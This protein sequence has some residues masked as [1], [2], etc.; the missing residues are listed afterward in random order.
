MIGA[1]AERFAL[2]GKVQVQ[3]VSENFG[4]AGGES[5]PDPAAGSSSQSTVADPSSPPTESVPATPAA[6]MPFGEGPVA[7]GPEARDLLGVE[8]VSM[9]RG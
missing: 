8:S 9:P 5:A 4:V 7:D 3:N 6:E 1:E 2:Q